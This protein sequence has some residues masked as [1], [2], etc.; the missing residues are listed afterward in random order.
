MVTATVRLPQP[1]GSVA[2]QSA[3]AQRFRCEEPG[4]AGE[5]QGDPNATRTRMGGGD[6]RHEHPAEPPARPTTRKERIVNQTT[7]K[8]CGSLQAPAFGSRR[9]CG[10]D[11]RRLAAL[12]VPAGL[13]APVVSSAATIWT[14]PPITFAKADGAD[15]TLP[16]IHCVVGRERRLCLSAFDSSPFP[17]ASWRGNAAEPGRVPIRLHQCPKLNLQCVGC[18]QRC[19]ALDQLDGARSGDGCSTQVRF[20]PIR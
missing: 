17:A 18:Y 4:N 11:Y 10:L 14:G 1:A 2:R 19:L 20:I 3:A 7:P 8:T 5:G 13:A 15:P 16:A 12:V 6:L 9:Q